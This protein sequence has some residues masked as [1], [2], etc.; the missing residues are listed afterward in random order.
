MIKILLIICLVTIYISIGNEIVLKAKIL[1][2]FPTKIKKHSISFNVGIRKQN[3]SFRLFKTAQD[4][5][6]AIVRDIELKQNGKSCVLDSTST[7]EEFIYAYVP[8]KE[9][10]T[11]KYLKKVLKFL[12]VD[13][14]EPINTIDSRLIAKII[15]KLESGRTYHKLFGEEEHLK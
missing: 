5:F 3:G 15:L 4:G 2:P 8:Q 1:T 9:N 7:I 12:D 6:D 14:D 10:D 11:E 13:R